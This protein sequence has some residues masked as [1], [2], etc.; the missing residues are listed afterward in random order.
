MES[1]VRFA[2]RKSFATRFLFD[3]FFVPEF[4]VALFFVVSGRKKDLGIDDD[5]SGS[6]RSVGFAKVVKNPASN[7]RE[8][9]NRHIPEGLSPRQGMSKVLLICSNER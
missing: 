2:L 5:E 6:G 3:F 9:R 1:V 7:K 8:T 4:C